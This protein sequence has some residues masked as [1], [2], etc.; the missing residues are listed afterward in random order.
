MEPSDA[1]RTLRAFRY[2][3]YTCFHCGADALFE[4]TDA[5]LTADATPS[6]VQGPFHMGNVSGS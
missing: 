6:P 3:L 2:S 5:I 4:L 1:L